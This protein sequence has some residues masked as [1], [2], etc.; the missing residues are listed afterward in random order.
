MGGNMKLSIFWLILI[1]CA[2]TLCSCG[3]TIDQAKKIDQHMADYLEVP[4]LSLD[5]KAGIANAD[6]DLSADPVSIRRI[7]ALSKYANEYSDDYKKCYS[8]V[9]WLSYEGYKAE[10]AV[11][12]WA[13]KLVD[14]GLMR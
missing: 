8:A 2:V 1:V 13:K 7:E 6:K 10:G 3:F 12:S 11:K 9:V 5:C 14:F 4:S